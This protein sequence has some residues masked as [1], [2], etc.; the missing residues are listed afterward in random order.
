MRTSWK[1]FMWKK[2]QFDEANQNQD[3]ARAASSMPCNASL[4]LLS[5][6]SLRIRQNATIYLM[7]ALSDNSLCTNTYKAMQ[8]NRWWPLIHFH[9]P[10]KWNQFA[11]CTNQC[12]HLWNIICIRERGSSTSFLWII[13][14]EIKFWFR[15]VVR[16]WRYEFKV[17]KS[18]KKIKI[19]TRHRQTWYEI[20][21]ILLNVIFV[22]CFHLRHSILSPL[23]NN[24]SFLYK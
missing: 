6:H 16:S 9:S 4:L 13:S 12:K 19:Q 18:Q 2:S 7:K 5:K 10:T 14:Q 23:W 8:S 11:H 15:H 20:L 1:P 21:K 3:E 22:T 24:F 17:K